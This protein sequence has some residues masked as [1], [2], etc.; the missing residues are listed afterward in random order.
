[1]AGRD[2]MTVAELRK[3]A[4]AK[5][6]SGASRMRKADLVQ[7][8]GA[9]DARSVGAKAA[10]GGKEP[11]VAAK[12]VP[13]RRATPAKAAPVKAAPAKAAPVKAKAAGTKRAA[14]AKVAAAAKRGAAAGKARRPAKA[15][16]PVEAPEI[17][18][19]PPETAS[20]WEVTAAKYNLN[21]GPAI[22][23]EDLGVLPVS[24]AEDRLVLVPRDPEW[25]FIYWELSDASYRRALA[26][27]PGGRV[28]LRLYV[29]QESGTTGV[30][31]QDVG[32]GSRRVYARARGGDRAMMAELGLRGGGDVFVT[33][34]RSDRTRIPV[35]RVR[36]G[37]PKFMSVPFDVPL[38]T[39]REQGHA[40]GGRFVDTR[41]RLL[42][43]A[44]Y[45]RLFGRAVPGSRPR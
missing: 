2:E 32:A 37:A 21:V 15:A 7:A 18:D 38:R 9:T 5:G 10:A 17:V 22:P 24:Y 29:E 40:A 8:L 27:V 19:S 16:R 23:D 35:A 31:E 14:G 33:M 41:G 26:L 13:A 3:L 20:V 45:H 44:E 36:P 25:V 30:S 39:L 42:T 28:V 6:I 12:A 11:P 43:E 34:V 4:I 1:M